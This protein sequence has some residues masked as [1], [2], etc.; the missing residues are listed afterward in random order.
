MTVLWLEMKKVRKRVMQPDGTLAP[1]A[2]YFADRDACKDWL[3][4]ATGVQYSTSASALY[5]AAIRSCIRR[6]SEQ[7]FRGGRVTGQLTTMHPSYRYISPSTGLDYANHL[8]NSCVLDR[9]YSALRVWFMCYG[10]PPCSPHPSC[11]SYTFSET[12]CSYHWSACGGRK[13]QNL[14]HNVHSRPL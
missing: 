11:L 4:M 5:V 9:Y 8:A 6:L 7:C 1:A 3:H 12:N 2:E 13:V 14:A 10:L